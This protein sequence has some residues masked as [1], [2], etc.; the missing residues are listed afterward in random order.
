MVAV[1][2]VVLWIMFGAYMLHCFDIQ[3]GGKPEA[4]GSP[5]VQKA[6]DSPI[7]ER[8]SGVNEVWLKSGAILTNLT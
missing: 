7:S 1:L 2:V 6:S 8:K 4:M 3:F 5:G